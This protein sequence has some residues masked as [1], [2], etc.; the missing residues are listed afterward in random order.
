MILR[1][2]SRRHTLGRPIL[3]ISNLVASGNPGG[4]GSLS[5]RGPGALQ[6]C[7]S[8]NSESVRTEPPSE[9]LQ[10][11]ESAHPPQRHPQ[12]DAASSSVQGAF[13]GSIYWRRICLD[14]RTRFGVEDIFCPFSG[15]D[16]VEPRLMKCFR[17]TAAGADTQ[18][19]DSSVDPWVAHSDHR[20]TTPAERIR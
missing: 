18:L 8:S 3:A 20:D 6:E 9:H 16:D 11:L 1:F 7:Q 19:L 14:G 10:K 13:L 4:L 15:P 17:P 5:R 12:R 2:S